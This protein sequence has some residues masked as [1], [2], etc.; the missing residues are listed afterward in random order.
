MLGE[1]VITQHDILENTTKPDS[2][3][4]GSYPLD[5]H[6]VQRVVT[7]DRGVEDEGDMWYRPDPT[8]GHPI[9]PYEIPYRSILPRRSEVTNLLVPVCL[10]GS[11][12]SYGT[13][14]TEPVYMILGHA[15]GV[16]AAIAEREHRAVQDVPIEELQKTLTGQHAVLHWKGSAPPPQGEPSDAN[17]ETN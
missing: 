17:G 8:T 11:H 2:I 5:S 10:S 9:P 7:P 16:A 12:V 13:L 1:Y 4:M 3:G 14:R 6:N 15:A